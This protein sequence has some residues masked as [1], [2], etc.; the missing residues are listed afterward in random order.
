MN[1]VPILS[2]AILK[3]ETDFP[4][5]LLNHNLITA[6]AAV[7]PLKGFLLIV[8]HIGYSRVEGASQIL[9]RPHLV[10]P[11]RNQIQIQLLHLHVRVDR[12][13]DL[14]SQAQPHSTKNPL[15]LL[16]YAMRSPS[17][18]RLTDQL[19]DLAMA[20]QSSFDDMSTPVETPSTPQPQG[21]ELPAKADIARS[22]SPTT[23]MMVAGS[24]A[25]HSSITPPPSSQAPNIRR[26]V[27]PRESITPEPS[28]LSS[29]PP[30]IVNGAKKEATSSTLSNRPTQEQIL[31]ATTEELQDM[32]KAVLAENS[33]L[34]LRAGEARMSAAHYK[35]QHNLLTIESEEAL[36]R[37][38]VEHEMTRRE[39]QVLQENK[40]DSASTEYNKKMK[41]YCKSLEDDNVALHRRVEK[42]KRLI[43]EKEDQLMDAQEEIR[44]LQDRIRTNREHFN[45]LRSP[46]GPLHISTPKTGPSTPQQY[47]S[48]PKHTPATNRSVRYVRERTQDNQEKFNALILAGS[49]LSQENNSAPSTPVLG[50]RPDPRTP[51]RHNRGVQSLSSLPTTPGSSR[52]QNA[53]S[54]LLPSAQFSP[55]SEARVA[56]TF[57]HAVNLQSH[58]RRRK[59]R[60]STISASDNED[61]IRRAGNPNQSS[62]RQESEEVQESQ[63]SQSATEMLRADPRESFEVAASRSATPTPVDKSL[64][65]AKIFG[66][67][68]KRKLEE[69]VL[70]PTP[71]KIRT[72]EGIGLG[73]GF[74][75]GRAS[76]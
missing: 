62:F 10:L 16:R 56:N 31:N 32:L 69:D 14:S 57:S 25:I 23:S 54:A 6:C 50:R 11:R 58:H 35:L 7:V 21:M 70:S 12:C 24:S 49:V 76:S 36:K 61:I 75:A 59:S 46:G 5:A 60:D 33:K 55:E 41:E 15:Q 71:K 18:T 65:Q 47:R 39:V 29:P 66:T 52:S 40:R 3:R 2:P 27:S 26:A 64:Q 34:A 37:M 72:S 30:T 28:L 73:I 9:L 63:A 1:L 68:T 53:T 48:T 38:E 45:I 42:A 43:E 44:R 8:R 13:K 51:S 74:E 4:T 17:D 22:T 67:V 19:A 20:S